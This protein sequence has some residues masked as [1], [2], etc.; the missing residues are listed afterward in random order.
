MTRAALGWDALQRAVAGEVVLPGSPSYEALRK[1]AIA[2]F[3]DARPQ[4]VVRCTTPGD[5]AEAIAFASAVGLPAVA[6]SGGHCFAGR[7]STGGLV[8]DVTPMHSVALDGTVATVGAGARLG[9]IYDALAAQRRTIAGG[10]GPTVGIAGLTLGGGL[11][12]LGRAHG[13]TCDQLLAAQVVL[14]DGRVVDCDDHRDPELFWALRGAGGGNLGVVTSLSFRTLPAPAATAFHLRWPHHQAAAVM[15]AWQDWAPDA[16]DELAASLL[17]TTT[18]DPG[19]PP[20]AHLFGAMA[21]AEADAG[22]LLD[23]LV[24]RAGADPAMAVLEHGGYRETKRYLADHGPGEHHPLGH[25]YSKSEFFRRPLPA[26]A[27]AALLEHLGA[28][29][30][31][32][33]SREL[34]LTPWGGAYNRVPADATAFPHRAERF[35]L[36]Q[37]AVVDPD[38]SA[39]DR[40]AAQAWLSRSWA[41]AHPWGSG[42]VYPNFPDPD[43]DGWA[44][45]YHGGNLERLARV[46]E[47]YDPDGFFRFPQS[48]ASLATGGVPA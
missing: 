43:L 1:P 3:H 15:A 37:A 46:R 26:E 28:G 7:S 20:E 12:I 38:A 11:G 48:L 36:K 23:E 2:R 39:A 17:V 8:L 21:G 16:P 18:D 32:G 31:A 29:R 40:Q 19:R 22:T 33:Q 10:C 27:I 4:A 47:R 24:A 6:R 34:D 5:V 14:A 41:L 25:P 30:V 45:A 42:G 44:R 13:L 9:D 35:L